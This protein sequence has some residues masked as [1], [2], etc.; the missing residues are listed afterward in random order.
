MHGDFLKVICKVTNQ[1]GTIEFSSPMEEEIGIFTMIAKDEYR[2][3]VGDVRGAEVYDS[4]VVEQMAVAPVPGPSAKRIEGHPWQIISRHDCRVDNRNPHCRSK[5]ASFRA[6]MG[7]VAP[8]CDLLPTVR[9]YKY[10]ATHLPPTPIPTPTTVSARRRTGCCQ[11]SVG[12]IAATTMTTTVV[13]PV[14]TMSSCRPKSII[15]NVPIPISAARPG[16]VN[17][18]TQR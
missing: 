2:D 5:T 10:E 8:H 15:A 7:A 1:E 11:A 16:A 18:K 6:G 3:D 17:G 12:L 4:P 14:V 9:K 13:I